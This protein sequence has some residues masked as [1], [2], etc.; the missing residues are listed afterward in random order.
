MKDPALLVIRVSKKATALYIL[1]V[2]RISFELPY[3]GI[4]QPRRQK[5]TLPV[6]SP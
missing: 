1:R 6:I 2:S 3:I 5:Q 4:F